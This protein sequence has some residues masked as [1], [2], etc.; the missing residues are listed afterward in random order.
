MFGSSNGPR[1]SSEDHSWE[2]DE[3][4]ENIKIQVLEALAPISRIMICLSNE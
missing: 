1:R 4:F 2:A 3:S